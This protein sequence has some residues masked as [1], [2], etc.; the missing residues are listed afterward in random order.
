VYL[1]VDNSLLFINLMKNNKVEIKKIKG[2]IS[3]IIDGALS[4]ARNIG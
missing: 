4:K 1:K 2:S 3:K